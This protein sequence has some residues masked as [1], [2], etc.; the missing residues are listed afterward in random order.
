[1]KQC[2]FGKVAILVCL[3]AFASTLTI[4]SAGEVSDKDIEAR[5]AWWSADDDR[6]ISRE[7]PRPIENM[8]RN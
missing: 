3:A 4:G 7:R 5:D 2:K 6:L 8:V 1:M